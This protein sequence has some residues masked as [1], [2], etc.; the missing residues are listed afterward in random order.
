MSIP[1]PPFPFDFEAL[2]PAIDAETLKIQHFKILGAAHK[3]LNGIYLDYPHLEPL[4]LREQLM[5]Q[6]QLPRHHG[7]LFREAAGAFY[8][9]LLYF[10][11]LRPGGPSQPAGPFRQALETRF[12]SVAQF[13]EQFAKVASAR[14][15]SGWAWLV[16]RGEELFLHSTANEINPLMAYNHEFGEPI[17]GCDVWEHAYFLTYRHKRPEYIVAFLDRLNWAEAAAN[18]EAALGRS[19]Q[20]RPTMSEPPEPE[21]PEDDDENTTGHEDP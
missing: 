14:R 19:A 6:A 2:E 21:A 15:G 3:R 1:L 7:F 8:N 5:Q 10:R 16:L 11:L 4:S 12:G 17:I 9:H 13:K 20:L 18:Y